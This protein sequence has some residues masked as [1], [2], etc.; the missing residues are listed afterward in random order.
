MY[1]SIMYINA[2]A[3]SRTLGHMQNMTKRMAIDLKEK[4][5]TLRNFKNFCLRAFGM[6][7]GRPLLFVEEN[8]NKGTRPPA[9]LQKSQILPTQGHRKLKS[10]IGWELN[11]STYER[12]N[13]SICTFV[14]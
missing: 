8:T 9:N 2:I 10:R 14:K 13:Q 11:L 7:A 12:K 3:F 1:A 6:F 4:R 5:P